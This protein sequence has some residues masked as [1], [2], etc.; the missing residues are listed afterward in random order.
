MAKNI[1]IVTGSVRKTGNSAFLANAFIKGARQGGNAIQKV[2]ASNRNFSPF[3]DKENA[4]RKGK[5]SLLEDDF[6]VLAPYI[7]VSDVLVLCS[8]VYFG[9]FS[10]AIKLFI[11]N[12]YAY[13]VPQRKRNLKFT[14]AILLA[15][16]RDND[17][18]TFVGITHEFKELVKQLEIPEFEILTVPGVHERGDIEG[19]E[20]LQQAIEL[21]RKVGTE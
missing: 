7:H 16:A 14:K 10:G 17:E 18:D 13:L 21:G 6:N 19:N 9:G 4:W 5:P 20:A 2:E 12:L 11:D 3:R 8:P 1:L 15:V